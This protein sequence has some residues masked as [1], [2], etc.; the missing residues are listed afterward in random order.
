M[1]YQHINTDDQSDEMRPED[2]LAELSD[3]VWK[4]IFKFLEFDDLLNLKSVLDFLNDLVR[5]HIESRTVVI[6]QGNEN[7]GR[8]AFS[9][10]YLVGKS[11]VRLRLNQDMHV[12]LKKLV[13]FNPPTLFSLTGFD[14]LIY[15]KIN[16]VLDF[17]SSSRVIFRLRNLESFTFELQSD[18]DMHVVLEAPKLSYLKTHHDLA[19]YKIIHPRSIRVLDCLRIRPIVRQMTNLETLDTCTFVISETVAIFDELKHLRKFIFYER[20]SSLDVLEDLNEINEFLQSVLTAKP[21]LKIYFKEID[22][23]SNPL[24]NDLEDCSDWTLDDDSLSIYQRYIHAVD[25]YLSHVKLKIRDFESL[26]VELIRKMTLLERLH[27]LGTI[28]DDAKWI[29]LLK[30]PELTKVKIKTAAE[31]DQLRLIP[32]HCPFVT[33][34]EVASFRGGDWVLQLRCLKQFKT[35]LLFDFELFKRMIK[36]LRDLKLIRLTESYQIKIDDAAVEC[37]SDRVVVLREPK[38]VFLQTVQLASCW[39]DLFSFELD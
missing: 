38:F 22:F 12:C 29:E 35:D 23:N 26:S 25:R 14:N 27:V 36:E 16:S 4:T 32:E 1:C 39:G 8:S 31:E 20:D 19:R 15:L 11:L 7:Y 37:L 30:L 5:L 24:Q 10:D 3:L 13:L 34:L 28:G 6:N 9:S 2:R 33:V 17:R 18:P 21:N